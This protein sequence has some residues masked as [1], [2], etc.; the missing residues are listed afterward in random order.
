MQNNLKQKILSIWIVDDDQRFCQQLKIFLE[1]NK[2]ENV[3]TFCS[4]ELALSSISRLS[5]FP[6]IILL[7]L[8]FSSSKMSG[9]ELLQSIGLLPMK[10]KILM[11]T[12]FGGDEYVR[13]ALK[14]GAVGFIDKI[15]SPTNI[16]QAIQV[17]L[18]GGVFVDSTILSQLISPNTI[19]GSLRGARKLMV[20][21]TEPTRLEMNTVKKWITENVETIQTSEDIS[22]ALQ[23]NQ[24]TLRKLFYRV[25][26]QPLMRYVQKERIKKAMDLLTTTDLKCFEIAF[27]TGF[28]REDSA[29]RAFKKHTG[30]TM[31]EYKNIQSN[32]YLHQD[33]RKK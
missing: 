3:L 4:C 33:H 11:L 24:E 18:Q 19:G 9:F 16:L 14:F 5:K 23:C 8:N 28:Q 20:Q 13:S 29:S 12:A 15:Q 26:Q 17:V 6:E 1:D 22:S 2:F 27:K 31:E 21:K 7:D 10:T 32:N 25:Y 30:Y